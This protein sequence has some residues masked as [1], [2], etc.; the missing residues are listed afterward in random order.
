MQKG[1]LWVNSCAFWAYGTYVQLAHPTAPTRDSAPSADPTALY[2]V[3]GPLRPW[4]Y[5]SVPGVTKA[6]ETSHSS[7][8]TTPLPSPCISCTRKSRSIGMRRS[9]S[10]RP[11]PTQWLLL[12]RS[13]PPHSLLQGMLAVK[14]RKPRKIPQTTFMPS[15]IGFVKRLCNE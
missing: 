1:K 4:D 5:K 8:H 13:H 2:R 12:T 3:S 7:I 15:E 10:A 11:R 14:P 6:S 9:P